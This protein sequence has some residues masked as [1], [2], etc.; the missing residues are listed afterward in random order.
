MRIVEPRVWLIA[1]PQMYW[2]Q[3]REFLA[4]VG[5]E[6]WADR[7][8]GRVP[9]AEALVEFGGRECYRSWEPGLN[10]NV[11]KV[12]TDSREYL[13]NI[14]SSGHGSVL[15]HANFSFILHDVSR[16][17]THEYCRHRAGNAISQESMRY[18]RLT[19]L[20][21]WLPQWAL[22]DIVF[23]AKAVEFLS[24]CE[25]FQEWMT[26]YFGLDDEGKP[27]H[28]KKAKTSFMRRFAPGGHAT[29]LLTTVNVRT[30]RHI[31]YM[32][33]A[34]GA[35]EEIRIVCDL[36]AKLA[37]EAVPNLMQD[38]NYSADLEWIPEFVKV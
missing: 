2:D 12:R 8:E 24:M 15:E 9:D 31:I 30:M 13:G 28:E 22:D 6:S 32:R 16:V 1:G 4:E 5:G 26:Q 33:T 20:P 27:F 7:V 18:V 17:F 21:F 19:D 29:G 35:E 25:E 14:L 10:A 36:M 23:M 38:Y 3:A 34:L 37:L 11:T